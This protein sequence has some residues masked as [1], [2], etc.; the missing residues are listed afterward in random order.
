MPLTTRPFGDVEAGDD[1]AAEH[2]GTATVARGASAARRRRRQVDEVGEQPQAVACRSAPGGT[3]RR[4]DVPRATA[5]TNVRA[6]GRLGQRRRRSP[7]GSPARPR[8]SGRSRSRRRRGCRRTAACS[9]RP[10]D[11]VPAD[12]GQRRRVLEADR[13]PGQDARASRRRPRRCPRTGA[14]ARGR[15]RGTAGPPSIQARIGVDEALARRAAPSPA[16]PPRRPG[17]RAASAP[18][19]AVRV[20]RDRDRRPRRPRSAWSMLTRLPAP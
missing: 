18:R 6:V 14:G 3:G 19:E 12:V 5:L 17:R 9:R 15:S 4:A 7:S 20:A 1:P 2:Q 11:L 13:A 8:T 16:P 10:L